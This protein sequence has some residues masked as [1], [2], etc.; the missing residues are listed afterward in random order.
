MC[1]LCENMYLPK[2]PSPSDVY[3]ELTH[4]I[5]TDFFKIHLNIFLTSNAEVFLHILFSSNDERTHTNLP[6]L[7]WYVVICFLLLV[8]VLF[9]VFMF[10]ILYDKFSINSTIFII[11]N[12][13]TL[14][15][16]IFF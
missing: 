8:L 13:M 10:L 2:S 3:P 5:D 4:H 7:L 16:S 12:I 1:F 15:Q 9:T 14:R 11:I 6:F